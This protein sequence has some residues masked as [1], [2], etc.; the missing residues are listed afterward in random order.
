MLMI[1]A[2]LDKSISEFY[3][4]I[5]QV[6]VYLDPWLGEVYSNSR[7]IILAAADGCSANCLKKEKVANQLH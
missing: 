3:L 7:W 4:G 2:V 5:I 1:N 6:I